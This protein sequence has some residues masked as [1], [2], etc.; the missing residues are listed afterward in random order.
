ME[1]VYHEVDKKLL[2]EIAWELARECAKKLP[3]NE[4]I[5]LLVNRNRHLRTHIASR[6]ATELRGFD[7]YCTVAVAKNMHYPSATAIVRE[8]GY[9]ICGDDQLSAMDALNVIATEAEYLADMLAR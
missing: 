2:R 3:N 6:D 7:G 4:S 8:W 9:D 1:F 5:W